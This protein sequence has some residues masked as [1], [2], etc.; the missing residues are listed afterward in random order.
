MKQPNK[1]MDQALLPEGE[2]VPGEEL[3]FLPLGGSGEIGMNLNLYGSEGAWIIVDLGVTFS[4]DSMPWIDV[5]TPDPAFIESQR[6]RLAGIVLTH[7]HEDHIGAVPHLWPRLQC[8]IYATSFTASILRRKLRE[9]G[10]EKEAIITEIPLSGSFEVGPFTIDLITL[11]HSIPEPNA[12]VIHS[13]HGTVLH[14]GD[15]KLDPNPI[16]GEVTD[17][18][19]LRELGEGGVLAMVCDSTNVF[20]EGASGSEGNLRESLEKLVGCYDSGRVVV[21]CF[22]SNI[23][24]LSTLARVAEANNRHAALIGRSLWS[25]YESAKENGY[26]TD[27]P[28]FLTEY[29]VERLPRDQVLLICTGSQGEPRAA[30]SRIASGNH[31]RVEL[32]KGDVAIFSSRIIP[33]NEKSIARLQ[34]RLVALGVEVV[35]EKD[36]FIHVSG[37]PGRDELTR[38]YQWVNPRVVVPV[39]GEIRHLHEQAKLARSCQIPQAVEIENGIVLRL[40]P[41]DTEIVGRVHSGRLTLDGNRL[42]PLDGSMM[43]AR[44]RVIFNGSLAVTVV[45]DGDGE[46][47]SDPVISA[48]GYFTEKGDEA[49]IRK[50][51]AAASAAVG[52]LAGSSAR[53]EDEVG[54]AVRCAVRKAFFLKRTQ[55]PVTQVHVVRL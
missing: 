6:D 24:R 40:A 8:P 3:L 12:V 13:A 29:D 4:D 54:E 50:L 22:A 5:I 28:E 36:H 45:I 14:T 38:M 43:A 23:A 7:A 42:V 34:N 10:L 18:R 55:R 2:P 19:A 9:M 52:S 35:T 44:K 11:T 47:L 46:L 20:T 31:P 21:G 17:E 30:F 27:I 48:P 15:W 33:G 39:H 41:G 53:N 37:H 32:E 51:I 49:F 16:V 1:E 26:L 25:F